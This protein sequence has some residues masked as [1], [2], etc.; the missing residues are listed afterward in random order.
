MADIKKEN[1]TLIIVRSIFSLIAKISIVLILIFVIGLAFLDKSGD[2]NTS[3]VKNNIREFFAPA[4]EYV[5]DKKNKL[6]DR[7]YTIS[8]IFNVYEENNRLRAENKKLKEAQNILVQ[9]LSENKRLRKINSYTTENSK[10]VIAK[11][12]GSVVGDYGNEIMINLGSKDE[13]EIGMIVYNKAGLVGKVQ[14]VAE[15]HAVINTILSSNSRIPVKTS[16]K[17]EKSIMK[18][19]NTKQ[20]RLEF[21]ATN[22]QIDKGDYITTS[23]DTD[24][25]PPDIP[26]GETLIGKDGRFYIQPF[27]DWHKLETVFVSKNNVINYNLWKKL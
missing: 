10:L 18:G 25:F 11:I 8:N 14:T 6:S 21:I 24:I 4:L 15:N 5:S 12:I 22:S 1:F 16:D 3:D 20:P 26:V 7:A 9:T 19:I 13:I 23:G 27:V 2:N 17:G